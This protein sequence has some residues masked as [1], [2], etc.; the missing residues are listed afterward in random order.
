MKS[1]IEF[2]QQKASLQI[3]KNE[4]NE[5]KEKNVNKNVA[6]ENLKQK[7]FQIKKLAIRKVKKFYF[8]LFYFYFI[9]LFLLLEI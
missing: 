8:Y 5:I 7:H 2:E 4:I 1:Q 3:V 9:Y 6:I